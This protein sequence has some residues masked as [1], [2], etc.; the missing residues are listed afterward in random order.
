MKKAIAVVFVLFQFISAN[1]QVPL[2]TNGTAYTIGRQKAEINLFQNGRYGINQNNEL[3]AH[4]VAVFIMPHIHL[5][6]EWLKFNLLT[7]K[8]IFSSKHGLYYPTLALNFSRTQPWLPQQYRP[9]ESSPQ[10]IGFQNELL[11]STLLQEAGHCSPPDHLLTLKL[12]AK[13]AY[14][15]DTSLHP[16]INKAVFFRETSVIN[17]E[18]NWYA[19]VAGTGHITNFLNYSADLVFHAHKL[20]V[21]QFSVESK[22]GLYGYFNDKL[23]ALLGLKL[24]YS[25]E[26]FNQAF[27]FYPWLNI[28]YQFRFKKSKKKEDGLF[29]RD[30]FNFQ[31]AR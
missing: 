20:T 28:A 17:P 6:H 31:N 1:A 9:E 3:L 24:I 18:L 14:S 23:S 12:G 7:K 21:E 15:I 13:Y 22:L 4:P 30:R 27:S 26:L 11:L 25:N 10:A 2:K 16:L 29:K 5:K 8:F 19:G